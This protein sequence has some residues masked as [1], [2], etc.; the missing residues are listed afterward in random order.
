MLSL[1]DSSTELSQRPS[2][3]PPNCNVNLVNAEFIG[4][5]GERGKLLKAWVCI[6]WLIHLDV[7]S[8]QSRKAAKKT[9]Q[10]ATAPWISA[11]SGQVEA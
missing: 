2:L 6:L 7:G 1:L 3:Q 11:A 5:E 8:S 9:C 4:F 10:G